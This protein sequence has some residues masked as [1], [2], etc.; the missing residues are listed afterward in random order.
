MAFYAVWPAA[1]G[2]I[3]LLELEDHLGALHHIRHDKN[4]APLLQAETPDWPALIAKASRAKAPDVGK[5]PKMSIFNR[6]IGPGFRDAGFRRGVQAS[7][8]WI[9]LELL[10]RAF[11]AV[12]ARPIILSMPL[13]GDFYDHAGVSRSAREEY[14]AKLR[15]L[16][17]RYGFAV[18][19]FEDHDEDP[20]FLIKHQSHLTAKGWVFYDR[21]L[22]NFFHGR[23]PRT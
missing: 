16:V 15:A 9:D 14:Y 13:P 4:P 17:R 6:Q 11:A 21:A 18:A 5:E 2:Q 1:R 23:R 19:E 20:G 12:G 10:L 8:I 7:P 3:A 22:D